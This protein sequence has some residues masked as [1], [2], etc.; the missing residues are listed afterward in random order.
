MLRADVHTSTRL[1]VDQAPRLELD[2][3]ESDD[4]LADLVLLAE[5][6]GL[7]LLRSFVDV[8]E[9]TQP[10]TQARDPG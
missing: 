2:H 3:D 8:T 10:T 5:L 7:L 6:T 9:G 4:G 1:A